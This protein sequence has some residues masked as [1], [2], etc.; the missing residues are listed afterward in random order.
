MIFDLINGNQVI[1][2]YINITR[3]HAL[4][5]I[6]SKCTCVFDNNT[7]NIAPIHIILVH[8]IALHV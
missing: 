8:C 1:I 6:A 5:R 4:A 3:M 2:N 7:N